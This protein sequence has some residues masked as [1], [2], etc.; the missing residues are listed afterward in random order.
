MRL[1]VIDLGTNSIRFDVHEISSNRKGLVQHRRLYREK[2]MVRLGQDLYFSGK[3]SEEGKRRTL[4]AVKSFKE[5]MDALD[6]DKVV[7]FGT[8]A[9]RDASDGEAFLKEIEHK[10]GVHFRMITGA[11]EASLIAKGILHFEKVP[12]GIYALI[13]IGGG[14][15]EVSICK[16]RKILHSYSFNLGV[17]KLQQVFLKTQPPK[18]ITTG[19]KKSDPVQDLRNFI[20]SVVLPQILIEHWPKAP[21]LLGSSGSVIA[22][23][24]LVHGN[25]DASAKP[26]NTKDLNKTVKSIETKTTEELLST[27]GMEPKRVDLILAGGILLD[28]ISR[29]IGAKQIKSTEFALRDGILVDELDHYH[30]TNTKK[31]AFPMEEVEKRIARWNIDHQHAD[32]VRT[33]S[34][35]LFDELKSVHQLDPKWRAYLSA[36]AILHD[37][38]EMVS[39]SHHSEHSEYLVKNAAFVGM[40]EWESQLI[41]TLCRYHKEEKMLEKQSRIPY[42]KKDELRLV[43]LKLLSLLQLADAMDRTHKQT[44]QLKKKK[45]SARQ[46][47]LSFKSKSPCDLEILRFEQKK[48]LFET[49]F[50]RE[51]FLKRV[52]S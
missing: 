6:V 25:R 39:H 9:V 40:H 21:R 48:T 49:L 24:K 41:A 42:D 3:F 10:T 36:A 29:C 35:W 50:K 33:Y 12:P 34:E 7:A 47:D 1:A 4:E 45:I 30:K 14:S 27:K 44:L 16:G 15:T 46:I 51:I 20:K 52:T 32:T 18:K 2:T 22:L 17:A 31:S 43:F 11:E 37:V 23:A 28:E 5:T 26:F 19:K 13:D 38:G 8:A